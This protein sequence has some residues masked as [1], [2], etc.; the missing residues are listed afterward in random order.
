MVWQRDDMKK[1]GWPPYLLQDDCRKLFRWFAD[2]VDARWTLRQVLTKEK[3][4]EATDTAQ[5]DQSGGQLVQRAYRRS[6]A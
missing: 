5:E 4:N 6:D 2:R 3:A 1:T